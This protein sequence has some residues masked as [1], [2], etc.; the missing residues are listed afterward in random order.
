MDQNQLRQTASRLIESRKEILSNYPFFGRLLLRLPFGFADCKTAYTDMRRIVFDPA[1]A[2]RLDDEALLF[3]LMHEV[4][5]CVLKHC[6]RGKGKLHLLYN[7]ACDIVVNSIILEALGLETISID[8]EEP[9]HLTPK[10]DEGRNYNAEEIYVMLMSKTPKEIATLYGENN[11]DDHGAW[12]DLPS[13]SLVSDIWDTYMKE[14]EK[15]AGIG[16]GI[17]NSIERYVREVYRTPKISWKQILND[18]IKHNRY[19]YSFS[20]PDKRFSD[21]ILL[22]S[23]CEDMDGAKI[24]KILFFVDTS[25][26]VCGEAL[27]EAYGEIKDAI[28]QLDSMSGIIHFFDTAVSEGFPFESVEDVNKIKPVG[29][30]GTDFIKVFRFMKENYEDDPPS[31]IVVITDG[32]ADFPDESDAMGIP[33]IWLI[34]DSHVDS[35]W[36]ECLHVYS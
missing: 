13:D 34:V 23:F 8:G 12:D 32:M 27:S 15:G 10:G 14:Q 11:L 19:D 9:M 31:V 17:P 36:G 35:P 1:F 26:S 20:T 18:Y 29:G 21:D 2:S 28:E 7:I 4:M 22:P 3:V 33:V 16:T 25:G 6:V 24:E 5:H 30:G